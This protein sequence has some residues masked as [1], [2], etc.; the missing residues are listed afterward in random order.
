[1][2]LEITK[3]VL[4]LP[5][6][7]DL[8][9]EL[10]VHNSSDELARD[11]GVKPYTLADVSGLKVHIKFEDQTPVQDGE[12]NVTFH[13][14]IDCSTRYMLASQAL[15]ESE[16]ETPTPE[17]PVKPT[18][19]IEDDNNPLGS[20]IKVYETYITIGDEVVVEYP[21]LEFHEVSFNIDTE[22]DIPVCKVIFSNEDKDVVA[23]YDCVA[24]EFEE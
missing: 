13:T 14:T 9:P 5:S 7:K 17:E 11:L 2:K 24:R 4:T 20:E 1:M 21:D 3:G 19:L 22:S 23:V 12:V 10:K 16:E 6:I 18:P 8:I 15:T